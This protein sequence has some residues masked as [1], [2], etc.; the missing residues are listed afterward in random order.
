M[1]HELANPHNY[2]YFFSDGFPR[3]AVLQ[4]DSAAALETLDVLVGLLNE[5][6]DELAWLHS[7][8]M[9]RVPL[10]EGVPRIVRLIQ[11]IEEQTGHVTASPYPPPN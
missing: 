3:H 6:A 7:E 10:S 2:K 1:L 11:K 9:G 8:Y 5:A 4:Q